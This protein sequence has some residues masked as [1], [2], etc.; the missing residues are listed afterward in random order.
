MSNENRDKSP[1]SI[2]N[3][4]ACLTYCITMLLLV[5][6]FIKIV[7]GHPDNIS[8]FILAIIFFLINGISIS[9]I[10]LAIPDSNSYSICIMGSFL[11][12]FCITFYLV[13]ALASIIIL[14]PFL[15][16]ILSY[17]KIHLELTTLLFIFA[18]VILIMTH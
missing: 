1:I 7:F 6:Y 18:T 13:G 12:L 14:L 5:I 2:K 4:N 15:G 3:R 16:T 10:Y 8:Q 17:S 11:S 9:N